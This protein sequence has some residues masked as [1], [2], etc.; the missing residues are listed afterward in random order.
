MFAIAENYPDLK[1]DE[2][3]LKLS[4]QLSKLEDEIAEA[5]ID[6]NEA[7]KEYNT[8]IEII[9][10]NI[11]AILFGFNEE[12]LYEADNGARQNLNIDL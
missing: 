9:P 12:K 2:Q 1:A 11:I 8:N 10:N 3:Y 6:Y 4:E 5:R 7:V